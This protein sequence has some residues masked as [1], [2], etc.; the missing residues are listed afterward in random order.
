MGTNSG[1][2]AYS[3]GIFWCARVCNIPYVTAILNA[4]MIE[5]VGV[6]PKNEVGEGRWGK[7]MFSSVFPTHFVAFFGFPQPRQVLAN[8]LKWVDKQKRVEF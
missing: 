4:F 5:G 7:K 8:S 2:L 6:R 1:L 3:E